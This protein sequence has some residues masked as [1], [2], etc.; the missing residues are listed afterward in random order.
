MNAYNCAQVW[1][2]FKLA[3]NSWKLIND[4]DRMVYSIKMKIKMERKYPTVETTDGF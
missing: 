1:E 2:A 3:S 4:D